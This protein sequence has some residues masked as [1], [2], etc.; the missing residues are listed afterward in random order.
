MKKTTDAMRP[1]VETTTTDGEKTF[2]ET[3]NFVEETTIAAEIPTAEMTITA[4]TTITTE[5]KIFSEMTTKNAENQGTTTGTT[6][7]KMS[8]R[9]DGDQ[10][11]TIDVDLDLQGPNHRDHKSSKNGS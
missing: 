4:V 5:R 10:R 11:T 9:S 6:G 3:T 1:A 8:A 2:A 7:H